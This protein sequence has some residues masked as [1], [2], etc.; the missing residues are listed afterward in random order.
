[1]SICSD[2]FKKMIVDRLV[3]S[4]PFRIKRI[5]KVVIF[6]VNATQVLMNLIVVVVRNFFIRSVLFTS[7]H[8][9]MRFVNISRGDEMD[10]G[11]EGV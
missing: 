3:E 4:G 7:L 1:M 11:I 9:N 10:R 2:D 6:D 8:L 5:D